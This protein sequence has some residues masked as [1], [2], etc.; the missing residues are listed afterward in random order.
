M[1]E[2]EHLEADVVAVLVV[3]DVVVGLGTLIVVSGGLVVGGVVVW[4]G[5]ETVPRHHGLE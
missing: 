5:P 2:L 1:V 4:V 3:A